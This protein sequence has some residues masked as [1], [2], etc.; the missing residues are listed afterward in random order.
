MLHVGNFCWPSIY[1][2]RYFVGTISTSAIQGRVFFCLGLFPP[3]SRYLSGIPLTAKRVD[4]I[5]TVQPLMSVLKTCTFSVAF[6][7]F[8]D[9]LWSELS[10][11]LSEN[12]LTFGGLITELG[13]LL[14]SPKYKL[15][16]YLICRWNILWSCIS[17]YSIFCVYV[18]CY[19]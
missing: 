18:Q 6:G 4:G 16:H 10:P 19:I 15:L 11:Q 3:Q 14:T 1:L 13:V 12:N 17:V 5:C 2:V 7:R 8:S 9:N